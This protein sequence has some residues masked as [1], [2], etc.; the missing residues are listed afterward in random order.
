MAENQVL[1]DTNVL[2]RFLTGE[3]PELAKKAKALVDR[4]EAGELTLIVLPLVVAETFYTL[5]S[6]Y[7][8]ERALV[9]ERLASFLQC[10]GIEALDEERTLDALHRCQQTGVHLVDAF[11]ASH[12][13]HSQMA[14]ATFDR[15]FE[16]FKDVRCHTLR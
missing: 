13:V 8:M 7:E 1:V 14:V 16:K 6:F 10:R 12:A 5:E 15:D 4:A 2:L 3:P 9:S 11:L